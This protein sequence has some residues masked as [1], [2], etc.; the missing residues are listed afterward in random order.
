MGSEF[1]AGI[2]GQPDFH[3]LVKAFRT[4]S[5]VALA[6][7]G[8]YAR[9]V[10]SRFSDVDLVRFYTDAARPGEAE[11]HL[12]GGLFVVVSDAYPIQ[13]EGW[14][15]KP[16]QATAT[17]AGLRSARSL[18][19][20]DGFFQ[21]IQ[22]RAKAFN[23]DDEMQSRADAWAS[24]EMVGWIEEVQKGLAGLKTGHIGRLLNARYGLTWGLTN[25]LR[26]QR[27]ILISG[28]NGSYSEVIEAI[29]PDSHWAML[30]R[31][32]YGIDGAGSLP[33]QVRAG[34]Q[35]YVHTAELLA[36]VLRPKDARMV[37]EVV[38]RIGGEIG[39]GLPAIEPKA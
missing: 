24:S 31:L 39:I 29:G 28:D 14:F 8:S 21:A 16:E 1:V 11:T 6:L 38:R 34:L 20:P 12:R 13:V 36:T 22:E 15:T 7:M 32:A 2:T 3:E 9:G 30:S 18:W 33:D 35:L 19:D 4:P 26:V 23:W 17:M 27:G 10:A 5:V 37:N 25:V